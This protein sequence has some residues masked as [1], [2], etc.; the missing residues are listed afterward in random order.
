MFKSKGFSMMG[1][2]AKRF[3]AEGDKWNTYY[4]GSA[5]NIQAGYIFKKNVELAGRYTQLR[6]DKWSL[7]DD[8]YIG[9]DKTSMFTL[10]LSKYIVKHSLKIQSDISTTLH[11]NDDNNYLM[12]RFQV[13][14]QF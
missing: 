10:G 14:M 2:Y 7:S 3:I 6:P 4:V 8:K 9:V 13:E 11:D 12:Y 5:Y 1:E